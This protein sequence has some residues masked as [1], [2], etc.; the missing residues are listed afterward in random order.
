MDIRRSSYFGKGSGRDQGHDAI[1]H[2][3]H[4]TKALS[5]AI[6]SA[7]ERG[8]FDARSKSLRILPSGPPRF[9]RTGSS[10]ISSD[11]ATPGV[12]SDGQGWQERNRKGRL[13]IAL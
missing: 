4:L 13:I 1:L 3:R 5:A 2:G 9:F 12:S 8:S 7:P 11:A 6:F 10:P